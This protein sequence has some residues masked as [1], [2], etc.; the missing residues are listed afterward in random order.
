MSIAQFKKITGSL[1]LIGA[2]AAIS[3][4]ATRAFFSDTETSANNVLV[5]GSIDLKVDNESYYNGVLNSGTSWITPTD[6]SDQLFFDFDDV[7][8][9]DYGEDTI[10]AH[11]DNDY[12]LCMNV[13]ETADDDVTCTEPELEDDPSCTPPGVGQGELGGLINFVWW[14]DDGDNVLEIGE[15][16]FKEGTANS[17]FNGQTWTVADSS[18][19]NVFGGPTPV[20]GGQTFY[21]G[22]AWCLGTLN[23]A[24]LP[25][26]NYD[27]PAGNNDGNQTPGQPTD[28]G[29]TCDGSLL[30]NASQTDKLMA[31]IEFTAVQARNNSS[32]VCTPG[33]T[34]TP[35]PTTSVTPTITPTPLA[36]GQADVLLV[37]DRSGS[38]NS[39]ELSSLKTAA[40][41]FVTSLGM[42]TT[43]VH[44]GMS[45]FA[46]TGTLNQQLTDS[47]ASLTASI[48]GLSSGGF[49]NLKEGIDLAS[50][51][52]VSIRDRID[53]TS[54]DVMVIVT[55]GHPNRPLPEAT[56]DDLAAASA[57]AA[58][59]AGT[60]IFV[61]GVGSDVNTAYL[62][63]IAS[64]SDHYY[65][66]SDYSGLQTALANLD[67]CSAQ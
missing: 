13:N 55:D 18:V 30:N 35:K 36:C 4:G 24:R 34:V 43:G 2:V 3:L 40:N 21:I 33:T 60:T 17:L 29:Y 12:W 11:A 66:A 47:S 31:D 7:K 26:S 16:V 52:L 15:K 19:L 28:G 63:G 48:N 49:T 37:L 57:T 1:I 67:L 27:S 6:L 41:S 44:G 9:G 5:A 64:G 65:P 58:K 23:K 32:F 22:K 61:V 14:V 53:T 56:A 10:S 39:T 8:P 59:G 62:Q 20:P 46:T 54:P 25:Q 42:S 51:E 38:I 50:T 45:S